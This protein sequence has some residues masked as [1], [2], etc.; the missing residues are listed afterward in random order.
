V[1]P[2][3]VVVGLPG[4]GKSSTGRRLAKVLAVEFADSDQ[5]VEARAGMTIHDLFAQR[6]EPAF[7][8]LEAAVVA[9]ALT[10]FAG[11]LSLGG[12]ALT[13][14]DTRAAVATCGA[15]VVYLRTGLRELGRRVGD[16]RTRPLLAGDPDG[17]LALLAA[18]RTPHYEA[19]ATIVVDTD[20]RTP[21]QVAATIAARLHDHQRRRSPA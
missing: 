2:T 21:G 15:P 18:E 16:G 14:D 13:R 6:G 8:D 20:D 5:L 4:A 17:R 19:L 11:V 3:A 9:D 1:T 7:R 10:A 12:G